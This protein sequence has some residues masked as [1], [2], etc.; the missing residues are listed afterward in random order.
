MT[1][2]LPVP[3]PARIA[4]GPLVASDRLALLRV[5][6]VEEALG[7]ESGHV[8]RLAAAAHPR[9]IGVR[10]DPA[11]AAARPSHSIASASWCRRSTGS[12]PS[13]KRW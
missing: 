1:R 7:L 2:V 6:V 9:V 13:T 8:P 10:F 3:A 4:T 5:E 12:I 11:S